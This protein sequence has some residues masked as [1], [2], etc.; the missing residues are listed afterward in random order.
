MITNRL[1]ELRES[2]GLTREQ[3]A[4]LV[5]TTDTQIYRL[6]T[7][8][9]KLNS[10]WL[11][12]F[13]KA[14]GCEPSDIISNEALPQVPIVG[15]VGAGAKVY[16]LDDMPLIRREGISES[17]QS[18]YRVQGESHQCDDPMDYVD[19]PPNISSLRDV[20]ALRVEG[21]S[22][23]PFMRPG[24]VVFYK[25]RLEAVQPD[26]LGALCVVGLKDESVMLKIIQKGSVPGKYSLQSYNMQLIENADIAWC[27]KVIS[28]TPV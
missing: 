14:Y 18:K 10:K 16:P 22:M 9:N 4:E 8:R 6:E 20:V 27:A 13:A 12:D 19:A 2:L 25:Q 21:D 15:T 24:T 5:G 3:A 28:I 7:G 26:W 17:K 11:V 1:K 23:M